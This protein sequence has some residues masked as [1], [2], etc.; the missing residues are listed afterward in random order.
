MQ[1]EQ[2]RQDS[3][4]GLKMIDLPAVSRHDLRRIVAGDVF[5]TQE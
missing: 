3:V 5:V 4:R 1:Q 2:P